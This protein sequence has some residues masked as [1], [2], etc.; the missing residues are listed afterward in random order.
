MDEFVGTDPL[1]DLGRE[2]RV[3][4]PV[5]EH[6]GR[7]QDR[8]GLGE[9]EF[10]TELDDQQVRQQRDQSLDLLWELGHVARAGV[11][12]TDVVGGFGVGIGV[13]TEG[14]VASEEP[15]HV[16]STDAEVGLSALVEPVRHEQ[17]ATEVP[18]RHLGDVVDDHRL[19]VGEGDVGE[20]AAARLDLAGDRELVPEPPA[21]SVAQEDPL[22]SDADDAG[23]G[24]E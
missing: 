14:Q 18:D 12:T 19:E 3:V 17:P 16:V 1:D 22:L 9:A 15:H 24:E 2:F 21:E 7:T 23:T 20:E 4:A 6:I 13:R 10:G 5:D 8:L 11:G